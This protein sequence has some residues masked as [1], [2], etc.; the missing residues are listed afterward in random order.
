[1]AERRVKKKFRRRGRFRFLY[2]TL[3][4]MLILAAVLTGSVLF[5]RIEQVTIEGA[6]K[7]SSDQVVAASEV[8]SGQNLLLLSKANIAKHITESLPYIDK[9]KIK[10]QF[11]TT[12]KIQIKECVPSAA[13]Q[14]DDA[15]WILDSK[16]KL[17]EKA[18]QSLASQYIKITGLTLIN[19]QVGAPA[20]AE[21]GSEKRLESLAGLLSAL[22][23][24]GML[25]QVT[26]IDLSA[27]T[28]LEMDYSG[29]MKV[30]VLIY[31]D[32]NRKM[33]IL[34]EIMTKLEESDSG[35][36]D[37]RYDQCYFRPN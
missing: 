15:W 27:E 11:P 24:G 19:P 13:V 21:T 3:S 6:T 30:K 14:V 33:R 35:E 20:Q 8:E 37:M 5:F 17:L 4:F 34:S 31:A 32:Y 9:V 29:R 25:D 23:D 36:I 10:K 16:C 22:S 7:Y 18:D 1:M 26:W 2:L 28:E 12:L